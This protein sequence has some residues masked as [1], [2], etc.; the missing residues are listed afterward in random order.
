MKNGNT[1]IEKVKESQK[2]FKSNLSQI[3][4]GNLKTISKDQL[5]AI[6]NINTLYESREEIINCI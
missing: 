4:T 6:E 3:A 2:Q 5:N 1:S